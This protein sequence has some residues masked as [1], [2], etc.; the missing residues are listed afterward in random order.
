M[1]NV[2]NWINPEYCHHFLESQVKASPNV[3]QIASQKIVGEQEFRYVSTE[4]C[5]SG[6][7]KKESPCVISTF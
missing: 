6:L 7:I 3:C 2:L 5:Y 1:K 4:R